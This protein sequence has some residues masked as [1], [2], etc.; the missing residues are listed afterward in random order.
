MRNRPSVFVWLNG[1]DMPPTPDVEQAYLDVEKQTNWPNP[2]ISSASQQP[3]TV[4]GPSGVK[5]TGPYDWVPPA[6]WYIDTKNGGAYGFNTE[7]SPGPAVPPAD[8]LRKFIPKDHEWPIDEVWNYH[9]GLE[10]FTNIDYYRDAMKQRYGSSDSMDQFAMRSQAVAYEGERAMF[11]AY[12]R[13]KYNSTG[14]I[15][16][17]LNNAWPSL[18]WHLYDYYLMP[19]GG[20]FG[21]KKA[22]EPLHAAYGY[23]DRSVSVIN[24]TYVPAK[25]LTVSTHV[26][27]FDLSEKYKN[28]AP[29]NVDADGVTRVLALPE[30]DGLSTTYFVRLQLK[31]SSGKIHSDNFYWLSTKPD[32]YDWSKTDYRTTPVIQ[33]GDLTA[34]AGLPPVQLEVR[35]TGAS[36]QGDATVRVRI[37]N[38]SKNLAFMTRV[39]VLDGKSGRDILPIR[40]NDNFVSMLPGE[41]R[42]LTAG[43]KGTS[44]QSR[45][46][47]RIEGWN[48]VPKT[49]AVAASAK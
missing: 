8:S 39:R 20:Y 38:P 43:Y 25:N 45:P 13:N 26:Y 4:T 27:N 6:Y 24:S 19:A 14:V 29:V 46:Q 31:D 18:I 21:T 1:S 15:Q 49:I 40:W 34:L 36:S 22:T 11:E 30:I 47:V 7:T 28:E 5:M 44:N 2:V 37:K 41:E 16:W 10:G 48:I 33:H 23:D 17:M 32:T 35:A 3:T 42:V 9:A 12:S